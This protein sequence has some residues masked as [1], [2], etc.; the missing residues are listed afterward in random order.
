MRSFIFKVVYDTSVLAVALSYFHVGGR[1]P[2]PTV[3]YRLVQLR[4]VM[5]KFTISLVIPAKTVD[6]RL[7]ENQAELGVLVLPIA[8]E[9]FSHGHGLKN[10][11]E[12]R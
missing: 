5:S 1:T 7:D 3:S 11:Y 9:M 8:L 12:S 10:S 2:N 4:V 6:A